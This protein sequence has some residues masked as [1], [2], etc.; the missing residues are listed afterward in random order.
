MIEK[1]VVFGRFQIFHLKHMEYLL[2]AKMRCKKLYIGIT[3]SDI[4]AFGAT[5]DLDMNG[6]TKRD[7]PMTYLERLE[8]IQKAVE[9]FGIQ[10]DAYEIIPFPISYPELI[11]QYAPTDAVYYMNICSEWDEA[12][13][14]I[15]KK[16]GL[17][18][19]VLIRK[20]PE[21][22]VVSSAKIRKAMVEGKEWKQFVSKSVSEYLIQKEIDKRVCELYAPFADLEKLE[23]QKEEKTEEKPAD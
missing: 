13:Y 17:N 9:D 14:E 15:L 5:N 20:A 16:M 4:T 3:H 11:A 8:M 10:K 19:E 2:A 1:G 7:N 23:P 22:V 12:Q 21:E 6:G 18:V